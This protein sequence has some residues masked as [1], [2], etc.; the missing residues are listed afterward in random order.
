MVDMTDQTTPRAPRGR[1]VLP[2]LIIGLAFLAASVVTLKT[3]SALFT[4]TT[5]NATDTFATGSVALA[6]NDLGTALFSVTNMKPGDSAARCIRVTYTGTLASSVRVYGTGL[7]VSGGQ[8][9]QWLNLQIEQGTNSSGTAGVCGTFTG[10]TTIFADAAVNTLG[11]AWASGSGNWTPSSNPT[12]M[13]Y[14]ITYTLSG[15]APN[16]TMS[17]NLSLTFTWEAQN[18]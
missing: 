10:A 8:L 7:T 11:T 6:D 12:T 17:Q 13:D 18:T 9:D 2:A 5:S 4:A 1:G 15:S 16:G 14:R 3:S